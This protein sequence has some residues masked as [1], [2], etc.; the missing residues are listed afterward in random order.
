MLKKLHYLKGRKDL[1]L[2]LEACDARSA[3]ATNRLVKNIHV[4]IGGCFLMT[5]ALSD[6]LFLSQTEETFDRVRESKVK[7]FE[8]FSDAV[9]IG[10][11]DFFVAF[12]SFAGLLPNVGQS[13]YSR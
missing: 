7:A 8:V 12:S 11:L 9:D 3:E 5:L 2:R 10:S 13:N 6:A 4:P 1:I